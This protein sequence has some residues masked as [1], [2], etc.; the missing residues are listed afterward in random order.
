MQVRRIAAF[1]GV[2]LP[3]AKLRAV[4]TQATPRHILNS[5]GCLSDIMLMFSGGK[6][7]GTRCNGGARVRDGTEGGYQ[8]LGE[9]YG[10]E[11]GG[12]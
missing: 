10:C 9:L 11:M 4:S 12:S 5:G 6:A 7:G 3:E 2:A 1:L 8:R